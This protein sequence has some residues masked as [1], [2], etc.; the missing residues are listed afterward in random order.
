MHKS[1]P[2]ANWLQNI[3]NSTIKYA[4]HYDFDT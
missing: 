3:A 2:L 1:D 4:T